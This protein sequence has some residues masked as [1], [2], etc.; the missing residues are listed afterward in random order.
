[1]SQQR[2]LFDRVMNGV[3]AHEPTPTERPNLRF[4]EPDP[5]RYP[6]KPPPAPREPAPAGGAEI[7]ALLGVILIV[8]LV[9][10]G[11]NW[12][13]SHNPPD[14]FSWDSVNSQQE[15][16][17]QG[18]GQSTNTD[19]SGAPSVQSQHVDPITVAGYNGGVVVCPA[20]SSPIMQYL[21]GV[22]LPAECLDYYERLLR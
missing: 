18:I 20:P 21:Q 19:D 7:M 5:L 11:I 15:E 12:L 6:P 13:R 4:I 9:G 10:L 17:S 3:P 1:M 2:T 22:Q 16:S 8:V 14:T